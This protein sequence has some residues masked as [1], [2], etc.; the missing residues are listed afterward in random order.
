MKD[1]LVETIDFFRDRKPHFNISIVPLSS[2]D[3]DFKDQMLIG[4]YRF[5]NSLEERFHQ[6]IDDI[7]FELKQELSSKEIEKSNIENIIAALYTSKES[8]EETTVR[9][10]TFFFQP[11]S[12]IYYNIPEREYY[13]LNTVP[14]EY[15]NDLVELSTIKYRSLLYF[16]EQLEENFSSPEPD[17]AKLQ[18][19][20]SVPEIALLFRLL[21][22]EKLINYKSKTEIYR[23]VSSSFQT[24]RQPT[25]SEASLKNKFN[26]PD[27]SAINN[28][29]LLISNFRQALKKL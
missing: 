25:I 9:D 12:K 5:S 26:S 17:K 2:F 16:I 27:S 3:D 4:K 22:E 14:E 24:E 29:N 10:R 23:F 7:I 6:N 13:S 11:Q 28:I 15:F 19:K 8:F 1:F 20:L 18:V 21:D